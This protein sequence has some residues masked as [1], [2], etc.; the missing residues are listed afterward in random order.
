MSNIETINKLKNEH[1][2]S[3]RELTALLQTITDD[4]REL[5]RQ[6]AQKTAQAVF[7]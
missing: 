5:L 1:S 4:E 2:A 7:F 6:A 3:R